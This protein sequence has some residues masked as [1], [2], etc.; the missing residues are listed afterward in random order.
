MAA[1]ATLVY[2]VENEVAGEPARTRRIAPRVTDGGARLV[3]PVSGGPR[4]SAVLVLSNGGQRRVPYV[5][6]AR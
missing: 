2:R 6:S 3:F 5:S 1:A 4:T